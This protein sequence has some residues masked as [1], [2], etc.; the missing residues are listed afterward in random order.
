L[1]NREPWLNYNGGALQNW[2]SF[3]A[4][5][6]RESD[7]T[8]PLGWIYENANVLPSHL[9][10]TVAAMPNNKQREAGSMSTD[11][12]KFSNG[13]LAIVRTVLQKN[14]GFFLLQQALMHKHHK[15]TL[16]SKSVTGTLVN[17]D[18]L[19]MTSSP[20]LLINVIRR[21]LKEIV[22]SSQSYMMTSTPTDPNQ[23]GDS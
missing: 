19:T 12:T 22:S 21:T 13:E 6:C 8:G 10:S 2:L 4:A 5:L 15:D 18:M 3:R 16:R 14:Q 7:S 9:Q 1:P 11:F 17:V 20:R 23:R